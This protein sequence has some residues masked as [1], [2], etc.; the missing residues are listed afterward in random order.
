M[1]KQPKPQR[2]VWIDEGS[3]RACRFPWACRLR[4]LLILLLHFLLHLPAP[5]S[6]AARGARRPVASAVQRGAPDERGLGFFQQS[7]RPTEKQRP[8]SAQS[9]ITASPHPC[10][11]CTQRGIQDRDAAAPVCHLKKKKKKKSEKLELFLYSMA[12]KRA[13]QANAQ[14]DKHTASALHTHLSRHNGE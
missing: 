2:R 6:L 9:D 8:S 3:C 4:V 1:E 7:Q 10:C 12:W 13:I 11:T 5:R 14:R